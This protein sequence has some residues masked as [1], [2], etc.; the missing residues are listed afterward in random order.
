MEQSAHLSKLIFLIG[1]NYALTHLIWE[2]IPDWEYLHASWSV[3][4]VRHQ[5]FAWNFPS[6]AIR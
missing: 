3:C 6:A 5:R 1:K 4:G 2:N